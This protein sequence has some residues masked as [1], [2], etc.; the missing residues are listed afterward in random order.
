LTDSARDQRRH[1][2]QCGLLGCQHAEAVPAV[3]QLS[4][5]IRVG[6]RGGDQIGEVADAYL[7][8]RRHRLA[9]RGTYR[10]HSPN[11]A[12]DDDRCSDRATQTHLP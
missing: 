4:A 11:P 1:P 2:P 9:C 6:D 7:G 10:G 8:V 5:R 3:L 12:V